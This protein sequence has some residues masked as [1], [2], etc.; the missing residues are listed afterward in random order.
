MGGDFQEE[1]AV[2]PG[3]YELVVGWL[4]QREAAQYEGPGIVADLLPPAFTLVPDEL[5]GLQLLESLLGYANVGKQ[6]SYGCQAA[7]LALILLPSFRERTGE[8]VGSVV[9]SAFALFHGGVQLDVRCSGRHASPPFPPL[10]GD[11]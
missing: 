10:V 5:N 11:S 4:A 1:I 7:R 6:G 8:G 2:A 9:L 3:V